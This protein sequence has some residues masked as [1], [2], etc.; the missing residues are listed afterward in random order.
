MA[1]EIV[2]KN[3]NAWLW[4][5][6]IIL[7]GVT[8]IGGMFFVFS[9]FPVTAPFFTSEWFTQVF[10]NGYRIIALLLPDRIGLEVPEGAW[11]LALVKVT[12]GIA[13]FLLVIQVALRL[14]FQNLLH[15]FLRCRYGHVLIGGCGRC[16]Q[17]LARDSIKRGRKVVMVELNLTAQQR[18]FAMEQRNVTLLSGDASDVQTLERTNADQAEQVILATDADLMNLEAATHTHSLVTNPPRRDF[19]R[20][21][22]VCSGMR[23]FGRFAQRQR[24]AQEIEARRA[25]LPSLKEAYPAADEDSL[26]VHLQLQDPELVYQLKRYNKFVQED[27]ENRFA[28]LPFNTLEV[29]ARRLLLSQPLY[30]YADLRG[31]SRVHV[32]IFG[33]SA[34]A[35]QL[36]LEIG[37]NFHYRDFATTRVTV[38]TPDAATAQ[39][40]FLERYP[41]MNREE[42]CYVRF[43]E[44]DIRVH[45]A[46][47]PDPAYGPLLGC[48]ATQDRPL[49]FL[50]AL[51]S[52]VEPDECAYGDTLTAIVSCFEHDADNVKTGLRLRNQTA[53]TGWGL[54]PVYL[55]LTN[56][57][58]HHLTT[59]AHQ[60]PEQAEVLQPFGTVEEVCTWEEIVEGQS[61]YL[62]QFL[63][64]A[65]SARYSNERAQPWVR[66]PET[67]RDANR[68][69]ADHLAVK[70]LSVGYQVPGSVTHWD[71][72]VDLR[73]HRDLLAR[74]EHRRWMAERLLD[75]WRY[76][77]E[78]DN[79]R[80]Q[81]PNLVA[82]DALD[83][84]SQEK[85]QNNVED[86]QRFFEPQAGSRFPDMG[87]LLQTIKQRFF[88]QAPNRP[89]VQRDRVIGVLAALPEDLLSDEATKHFE[90]TLEHCLVDWK[91]NHITW[92]SPLSYPAE[93]LWTNQAL[94]V[95][96]HR[97]IHQRLRRIRADSCSI[98]DGLAESR[99]TGPSETTREPLW[100]LDYWTWIIDIQ[101]PGG[102]TLDPRLR[103]E[104][105]ELYLVE[106]VDYLVVLANSAEGERLRRWCEDPAERPVGSS[107]IPG[108][109]RA[110]RERICPGEW[111]DP[112]LGQ[113]TRFGQPSRA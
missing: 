70:L 110:E 96:E 37:R 6:F 36:I 73:E 28:T 35:Q 68:G 12:G 111:I 49:T 55:W 85:D 105:A 107:S 59:P 103:R 24:R 64:E 112:V 48:S 102:A 22:L 67:Y 78:R 69:A 71:T 16:A 63:H 50:E 106:R 76:A 5:L 77:P 56:E 86:I 11:Y 61:D 65:Y 1:N 83:N 100:N 62:A 42:T 26:T 30:Y 81:H 104:R 47:L 39:A 52:P 8:V 94:Q 33:Y 2:Q 84:E 31:Q 95:G 40:D 13:F 27:R 74:L 38:V 98:D 4:G 45:A 9:A 29:A 34:M 97:G 20:G 108:V 51:G 75:G 41:A 7:I 88:R 66:L 18:E 53:A 54:A 46:D 92:V 3:Q 93:R 113:G 57:A 79:A 23:W 90:W 19:G 72:S 25:G 44:F 91:D 101:P 21:R 10:H 109:L 82:Y 14:F 99:R 15:R 80:K 60:T 43:I 32:A 89:K 87:E 17:Q 58:L